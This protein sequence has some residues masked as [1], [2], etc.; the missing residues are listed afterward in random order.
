MIRAIIGICSGLISAMSAL[1]LGLMLLMGLYPIPESVENGN[2]EA[3]NLFIAGLSDG[4]FIIKASTHII[5]CFA[6]G[7]VASIVSKP[8]K[9]QAGVVAAV[10]VFMLV[11]FRDFRYLYPSAYVVFDLALSAIAGFAGV[12]L[13]SNR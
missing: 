1:F 4:A 9:Y 13:G 7:L 5:A 2:L 12:L 10:M 11:V 3:M 6:S 8:Y